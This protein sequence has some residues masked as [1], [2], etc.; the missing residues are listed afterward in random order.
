MK[1]TKDEAVKELSAKYKPRY[2]EPAKWERTIGECVEHALKLI[3][4]E[5]EIELDA[6]VGF[7]TPFLD[8]TAGFLTKETSDV[9]KGL[10]QQI[11]D[12]KKQIG[13]NNNEPNKNDGND[14]LL[15]RLEALENANKEARL[16]ETAKTK[17]G[18]IVEKLKA[19]GVK[20]TNWI[21]LMLSKATIGEDT[22]TEK[23]AGEYLEI[24]NKMHASDGDGYTPMK[25]EGN[26]EGNRHSKVI[27][28]AAK[29]AENR[30][31]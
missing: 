22:D 10:N 1:F 13:S 18:E 4:E 8:T 2:G 29:I 25:P 24:Y 6:F 16:R 7:V 23:E 9:A 28:A 30:I 21:D 12:L 31:A 26:P 19:K 3:G 11:E 27:E 17:R 15:K 20:D 14:E 5:S